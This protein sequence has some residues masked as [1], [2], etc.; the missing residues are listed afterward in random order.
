ME[1][2]HRDLFSLLS[3]IKKKGKSINVGMDMPEG[4]VVQ[5]N[6]ILQGVSIN[7][8]FGLYIPFGRPKITGHKLM[9]QVKNRNPLGKKSINLLFNNNALIPER[10]QSRTLLFMGTIHKRRDGVLFVECMYF[11]QY[12]RQW[13]RSFFCLN[14]KI[15][16]FCAVP[17][18][19]CSIKKNPL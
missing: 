17:I 6:L 19:R 15:G 9:D 7:T 11:H 4:W 1:R 2:I 3:L 5:S 12:H 18:L 16:P 13:K 14:E 10:W 8:S